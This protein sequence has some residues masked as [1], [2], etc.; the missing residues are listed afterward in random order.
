[1][2]LAALTSAP[3]A[4]QIH[5]YSALAAFALGPVAL[6]CLRGG[7]WHKVAGYVW[8]LLM[9]TA[10]ATSLFI[11]EAPMLGPFSPIHILSIITFGGLF[12]ALRAARA[13]DFSAHGRT[14]R[15]LY[16]QALIIAGVFTFLPGR[17]MNGVFGSGQD[18]AV[19]W[20][21]VVFGSCTLALI[22]LAPRLRRQLRVPQ[23][24]MQGGDTERGGAKIPLFFAGPKR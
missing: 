8:V 3:I 22:F 18:M 15:A 11:S 2:T 23:G 20:G 19:F 17:R 7:R 10:A 1:M 9:I 13:R 24:R 4:V 16:A 12:Y 14:M 21:A 6:L 5:A